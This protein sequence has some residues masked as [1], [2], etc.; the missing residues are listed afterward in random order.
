M[1][2]RGQAVTNNKTKEDGT[3]DVSVQQQ[4]VHHLWTSKTKTGQIVPTPPPHTEGHATEL[5]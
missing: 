3:F 1:S 5:W 2:F 4:R